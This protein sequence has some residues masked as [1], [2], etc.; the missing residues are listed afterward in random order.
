MSLASQKL[1]LKRTSD[2]S[3]KEEEARVLE[4][5]AIETEKM[6]VSVSAVILG[7]ECR[8]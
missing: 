4:K 6:K 7:D 8:E 5:P 1:M 2:V 3:T